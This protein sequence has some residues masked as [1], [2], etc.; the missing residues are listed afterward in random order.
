MNQCFNCNLFTKNSKFCCRRCSVAYNNKLSPKR[1]LKNKCLKCGNVILA[2][3]KYC[4]N[5]WS[6]NRLQIL[7][8][9]PA[10]RENNR[11]KPPRAN[12]T[13]LLCNK[14]IKYVRTFCS[15]TCSC[16]YRVLQ[17]YK[18]IESI[19]MIFDTSIFDTSQFAKKY[20]IHKHGHKCSVC[21]I[22]QWMDKPVPLVLDHID[23]RPN[24]WVL[25]NLRLVCSNCDAQ[26][27]TFTSKNRGNGGRP[28]R[29]TH[30]KAEGERVELS[31]NI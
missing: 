7:R 9:G 28:N 16:S 3:R 29:R 6:V 15:T 11:Q 17:H 22:T 8:S 1:K 4:K 26:L 18:H 14:P 10:V 27:P 12:K 13:C 5:C 24:N 30:K 31:R 2:Q 25:S 20:M 19:G 21:N 23:G